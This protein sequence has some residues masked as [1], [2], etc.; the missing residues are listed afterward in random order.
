MK[1]LLFISILITGVLFSADVVRKDA[2]YTC[3][4]AVDEDR[5]ADAK[6]MTH[7]DDDVHLQVGLSCADCH[8]GD[9]TAFDDPDAAMWDDDT[10][11]GAVPRE[12]QPEVCGKCHTDPNFMR[13]YTASVRTDEIQQYWTS[14]HGKLLKKGND[15]VAVCTSCHGVHGIFPKDDPRSPVYPTHVPETCN[16]CHGN[17]DYMAEFDIPTDQFK[18]YQTSVHGQALLENNDLG[19]PACNDCHGNHGAMPPDVVTIADICGTCHVNNRK[20]F[21]ASHLNYD[22]LE[23]GAKQCIECHGNHGIKHPTDELLRVGTQKFVC[24]SCHAQHGKK[25]AILATQMDSIIDSLSVRYER[26]Q[27]LVEHAEQLGMEVS[28]LYA[29]LDDSRRALIQTRTSIH[30]FNFATVQKT[31]EPG[32]KATAS[33]LEGAQGALADYDQR[34]VNL[35]IMILAASFLVVML[36]LKIKAMQ[37]KS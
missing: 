34:R 23:M 30:S 16:T 27:G 24:K 13:Q 5:D 29:D 12:D 20:L 37:N 25:A 36:V 2:C 4:L 3:H 21:V 33:A 26:A 22:M 10:F 28:D 14:Q 31:A 15:K 6:I 17:A 1:Q 8:G 9:P 19:A 11:I 18:E 32:F 7:I 35:F